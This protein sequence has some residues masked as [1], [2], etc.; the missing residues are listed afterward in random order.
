MADFQLIT[1]TKRYTGLST[2]TKPASTST[3]SLAKETDT[4]SEFIFNGAAWVPH[5]QP[6]TLVGSL[7]KSEMEGFGA[8][9]AD[10]PAAN[11][12]PIGFAFMAVQ[13][14]EI[15]QSDGTSWV[16]M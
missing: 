8:T 11:S 5:S 15:W 9:I 14:Q 16:V 12:V 4:G 6:T 2:D 7:P 1:S 10:R 13:T 3:G